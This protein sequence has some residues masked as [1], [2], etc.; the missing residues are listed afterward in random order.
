MFSTELDIAFGLKR[1]EQKSNEIRTIPELLE[2]LY[3]NGFLASIDAM[4]CQKV[5]ARKIVAKGGDYLVMVKGKQPG[6]LEN[7]LTYTYTLKFT[8]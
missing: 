6:L 2:V 4:G 7:N 3:I 1:V 5:I 8:P